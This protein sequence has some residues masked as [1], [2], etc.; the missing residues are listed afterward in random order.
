[1]HVTGIVLGGLVLGI[2]AYAFLKRNSPEKLAALGAVMASD[3][4]DLAEAHTPSLSSKGLLDER[5][6]QESP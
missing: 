3:E 4:I 2:A 5:N 1:M 6:K